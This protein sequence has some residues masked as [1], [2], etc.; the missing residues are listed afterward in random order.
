VNASSPNPILHSG[1]MKS[2]SAIFKKPVWGSVPKNI[3]R[4]KYGDL[5]DELTRNQQ[6]SPK[7]LIDKGFIF[8]YVTLTEA[9]QAI[10][11]HEKNR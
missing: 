6:V 9:L 11:Q 5:Y 7:R 2:L 10:K 3:M 8:T 1:F 4:W